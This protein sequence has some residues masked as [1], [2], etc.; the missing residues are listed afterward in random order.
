LTSL[1]SVA[2]AADFQ[3]VLPDLDLFW[4]Y[5]CWHPIGCR[6]LAPRDLLAGLAGIAPDVAADL[7]CFAVNHPG[8]YATLNSNNSRT[9]PVTMPR[10]TTPETCTH[11]RPRT[12]PHHLT[13][14]TTRKF[15]HCHPPQSLI[16]SPPTRTLEAL[17]S[18]KAKSPRVTCIPRAPHASASP[19]ADTFHRLLRSA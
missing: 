19:K 15:R 8:G 3:I 6:A 9:G 14:A 1:M 13:R 18:A 4:S 10:I 12:I 5:R 2:V 17:R 16:H 11:C 7:D